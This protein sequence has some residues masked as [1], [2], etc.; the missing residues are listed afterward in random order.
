V[1]F[2]APWAG[3]AFAVLPVIVVFYLLK[4]RREDRVVSSTLL[5]RRSVDNLQANSP[6]ERLRANLLLLLQLLV[7]AALAFGLTRPLMNLASKQGASRALLIDVSGSM[8]AR[9]GEGG[10][11]RMEDAKGLA[12][13]QIDAMLPGDEMMLVAFANSGEV[14]SS[15]T[16]DR[17]RLK[18]S[19]RGI[20]SRALPTD[21]AEAMS[22]AASLVRP[23]PQPQIV[24]ISDGK[25]PP[26]QNAAM[27]DAPV[28]MISVGSRGDNVGITAVD[29]R[30][31]FSGRKETQLFV[32]VHNYGA[33]DATA[34]LDL[35]HEG[36]IVD[37]RRLSLKAGADDSVLFKD[38]GAL[39]GRLAISLN[40][41]DAFP[42]DD[43]AY[44]VIAP[45][46]KTRVALVTAANPFLSNALAQD[47]NVE[48]ETVAP[49]SYR[50]RAE[51]DL[52]IFDGAAPADLSQPGVYW[53]INCLPPLP[54]FEK[55]GVEQAPEVF[56]WKTD[57]PLLRFVQMD[58]VLLAECLAAKLPRD[59]AVLAESRS[60]P[61]LALYSSQGRECLVQTFDF[62]NSNLP[63]R[64]AFP[65]FVSNVLG[66]AGKHK[67]GGGK[68][69]YRA[70]EL[71]NIAAPREAARLTMTGP[72][73]KSWRL[74]PDPNGLVTFDKTF[75]TGFYVAEGGKIGEYGVSLLSPAES[76]IAPQKSFQMGGASVTAT[77]GG[78]IRK[79]NREVWP[80]FVAAALALLILEWIIYHRRIWV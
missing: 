10:A 64:V 49:A 28:E 80:W 55:T 20:E 61:L 56:D 73:G 9:D 70:G 1:K 76:D 68:V 4:L 19:V 40:S 5:W 32:L 63:Y 65:V 66:W 22:L 39:A 29:A 15:F 18:G 36:Q 53:F 54:G 72:D 8:A 75:A 50:A 47:P 46:V 42:L 77:S 59:C 27:G 69:A 12:I 35:G 23:R 34:E 33:Q 67:A 79:T 16:S 6:F 62:F 17:T 74:E 2:L 44:C 24:I 78:A 43:A 52:A 26:I 21:L 38:L 31:D 58:G 13:E 48:L 45:P 37:S 14:L 51:I 3:G 11:T 25:F 57:H 30:E 71:I 7:A 60:H 41:Q